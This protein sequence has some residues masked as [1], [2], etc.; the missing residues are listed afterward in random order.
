MGIADRH[1]AA[2]SRLPRRPP[3]RGRVACGA[4]ALTATQSGAQSIDELSAKIDAAKQE[5]QALGSQIQ[6]ATD[7]LA[8]AQQSAIDAASAR[9]SSTPFFSRGRRR[10]GGSRLPWTSRRAISLLRAGN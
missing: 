3:A 4:L 9:P 5:A 1:T 10:N 8:A 7:Q 2:R 6:S